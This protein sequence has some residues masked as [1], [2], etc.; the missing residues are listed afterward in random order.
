MAHTCAKRS[1]F[2]LAS[3]GSAMRNQIH[4]RSE[5]KSRRSFGRNSLVYPSNKGVKFRLGIEFEFR[6]AY[7]S[8]ARSMS[9]PEPTKFKTF[10]KVLS[11]KTKVSLPEILFKLLTQNDTRGR[12]YRKSNCWELGVLRLP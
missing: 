6:K 8:W 3:R 12:G 10:F 2:L 7:R 4:C 9:D 5:V 11:N 1:R